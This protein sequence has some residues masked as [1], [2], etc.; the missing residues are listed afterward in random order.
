MNNMYNDTYS[1]YKVGGKCTRKVKTECCK[2]RCEGTYNK[3]GVCDPCDGATIP[4]RRSPDGGPTG[5]G[6]RGGGAVLG[7]DRYYGFVDGQ[8]RLM[9]TA[10][11]G[12]G[13]RLWFNQ[14][15]TPTTAEAGMSVPQYVMGLLSV[16]VLFFVIGYGYK[17]GVAKA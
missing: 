5:G 9:P 16:G 6:P 1:N 13:Q 10:R 2:F 8:Q 3:D 12:R 14:S 11:G 4:S 17:K 15:G 7:G